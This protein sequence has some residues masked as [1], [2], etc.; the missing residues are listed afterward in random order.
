M[1]KDV[2]IRKYMENMGLGYEMST[3]GQVFGSIASAGSQWV[4]M[5]QTYHEGTVKG[6]QYF[7]GY[8]RTKEDAEEVK[9]GILNATPRKRFVQCVIVVGGNS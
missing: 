2:Q 6:S 4:V 8:Y 9:A 7:C 5:G 1:T 3:P